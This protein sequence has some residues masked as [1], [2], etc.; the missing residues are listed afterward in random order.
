MSVLQSQLPG[1]SQD[2]LPN[3]A[4]KENHDK[5]LNFTREEQT[6]DAEA[7]EALLN[8]ADVQVALEKNIVINAG[9]MADGTSTIENWREPALDGDTDTDI[10]QKKGV[11]NDTSADKRRTRWQKF[12]QS[13]SL[14]LWGFRCM[15]VSTIPGSASAYLL[16]YIPTICKFQGASFEQAA[17]LTTIMGGVD[18]VSRISTGFIADTKVLLPSRLAVI[19]LLGLGIGCHFVRYATSFVTL[20]PMIVCTAIF[21]G[22]RVPLHS[23][24]CQEVVGPQKFPQAYSLLTVIITLSSSSLNPALG[25]VVE[26]TGSFVP[27]LHILGVCFLI[28]AGMLACLPLF[29]RLD[30]KHGKRK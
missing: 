20:I 15:L 5:L 19:V 1:K 22:S 17:F 16:S 26:A 29:V 2:E 30:V 6:G 8:Q 11:V 18:L 13:S 14:E 3:G 4:A 12:W 24:M 10:E 23:L 7:T 28:S 9:D 27:V 21:L 25:A